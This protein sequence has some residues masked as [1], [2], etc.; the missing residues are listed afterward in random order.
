MI[1]ETGNLLKHDFKIVQQPSKTFRIAIEN[2]CMMGMTDGVEALKQSITCI[3]NTERYDWLIYSWNYGVELKNL[4][5]KSSGLVKAKLRKRITEALQQDDRIKSV[6]DF[7]FVVT[8]K[9]LHVTFTVHSLF[10][11]IDVKKEVSI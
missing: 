8:G 10:G 5:G 9:T 3:L 6:D 1:P 2:G 4:F 7:S 11:A